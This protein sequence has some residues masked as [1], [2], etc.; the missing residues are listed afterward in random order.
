MLRPALGVALLL[1]LALPTWHLQ[2]DDTYISAT[3]AFELVDHGRLTWAG[4]RVVEGY[5]N[6]LWVLLMT[7]PIGLGWDPGLFVQGVSLISGVALVWL[8][9]RALG[10]RP[11]DHA[12]FFAATAWAPLA[13]WSAMGMETVFFALLLVCGWCELLRDGGRPAGAMLLL[14]LAALTRPEGHA[15]L[16]V[17]MALLLWNRRGTAAVGVGA[18]VLGSYHL[19]RVAWFG[20][21]LPTPY[22]AKVAGSEWLVH[23]LTAVGLEGAL[24]APLVGLLALGWRAPLAVWLPLGAHTVLLAR[25]GGD[26]MAHG[27]MVLPGMA[28]TIALLLL[29]GERREPWRGWPAL[30]LAAGLA[31][32]WQVD[33][34]RL[35]LRQAPAVSEL[36]RLHQLDTPIAVDL[37]W[38][39]VHAPAD[40][41]VM[42]S[43]VGMLGH[44]LDIRVHD[45]VGLVDRE[46][47]RLRG[48]EAQL[49]PEMLARYTRSHP[50][51]VDLL[52]LRDWSGEQRP[53][54]RGW[55][56]PYFGEAIEVPGD[57]FVAWYAAPGLGS[58]SDQLVQQRFA[59]LIRRF[60]A[61]PRIRFERDRWGDA[62]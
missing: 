17:A 19:A 32:A 53:V 1:L 59:E 44:V 2:L 58:P 12:V 34:D 49:L 35:R 9:D 60:P 43:D 5:S 6:F 41:G 26:W 24:L 7:V 42:S 30:A 55:A 52:R 20:S 29:L 47:V 8:L 54:L 13:F 21:L 61:Q 33:L 3:Y 16:L 40:A 50:N 4:G 57:A 48:G 62:R 25:L 38:T 31:A 37:L 28:L 23:G 10:Q 36:T 15:H 51:R 45:H 11:V 56:R 39:V 14:V 46:M 22:L 27:R 18:L